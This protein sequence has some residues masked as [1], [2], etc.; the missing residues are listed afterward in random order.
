MIE[1]KEKN[2]DGYAP[3]KNYDGYM[4]NTEKG[5]II[6]KNDKIMGYIPKGGSNMVVYLKKN[7]KHLPHFLNQLVYNQENS[8]PL[9]RKKQWLKHKDKDHTNCSY[10]N[11]KVVSKERTK[12]RPMMDIEIRTLTGE[13]KGHVEKYTSLNACSRNTGISIYYLKKA[14]PDVVKDGDEI[15]IKDKNNV[16]YRITITSEYIDCMH[17]D[18]TGFEKNKFWKI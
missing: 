11:L 7:G 17:A 16:K 15:T 12:K 6:N 9:N 8:I 1:L 2:K 14:L 13:E 10:A 5:R 4:I 3:L 18:D